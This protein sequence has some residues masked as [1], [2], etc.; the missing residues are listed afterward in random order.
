[1]KKT[2]LILLAF[3]L[4]SEYAISRPQYSILQTYGTKCTNCHINANY[5]GARNFGGFLARKDI[6]LIQPDDIGLQGLYDFL[7]E[8]T[9]LFDGT[10]NWGLDMRLQN[11]RWAQT[12]RKEEVRVDTMVVRPT[13]ER[14]TMLMQIAP[15]V[16]IQAASWLR[17]EAM[18]NFAYDIHDDMRYPGQQAFYAGVT[19]QP[20]QHLPSIRVG[21]LNPPISLDFDDHTMLVR[22]VSGL[23]RSMPLIPADY[24]ELGFE[25]NYDGLE[26]LNASFGM[27]ESKNMAKIITEGVPLVN[28]NTMSSVLNLSVHPQLPYGLQGFMGLSHFF[29]SSLKTD[30][31]I[32]FGNNY[33]T[34]SSV[35]L[36]IGL[37][38]RVALMAEY[39]NS[40]KQTLQEVN[41][42]SLELTYQF[43]EPIHVFGRYESGKTDIMRSGQIWEAKQYVLG[44]HIYPL[45]FIDLIPEYRIYDRADVPGTSAQWAFQV[46]IFY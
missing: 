27:Y 10:V 37:A 36:G 11:A 19:I 8:G 17:I 22:Q 40:T 45:P 14:K 29:N 35:Y 38:D 3:F 13:I 43:M 6:G 12:S 5:G 9:E 25:I 15:Y 28:E 18:Y 41:N 21:Y 31:G 24:A 33:L 4:V 7:G 16:Q 20:W 42:Y 34:I 26:W 46:H 23:G 30:D 39:I 1:M 44:A 32:Y 2:I